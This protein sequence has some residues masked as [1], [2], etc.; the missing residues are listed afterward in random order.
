MYY[1]NSMKFKLLKWVKISLVVFAFAVFLFPA[2]RA[3]AGTEH[4]LFGY[5]WSDTVGWISFNNCPNP[6]TT[7]DCGSINYG[8]NL[9]PITKQVSGWAWSDNV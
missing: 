5:A 6:N 9:D 7:T 8:V 1:N 3:E 2:T 4:N